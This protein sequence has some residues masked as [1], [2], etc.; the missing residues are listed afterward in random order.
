MA[1]DPLEQITN[2]E[3]FLELIK[4][5]ERQW[6]RLQTI[7][8]PGQELEIWLERRRNSAPIRHLA[9]TY[10]MSRYNIRQT[11]ARVEQKIENLRNLFSL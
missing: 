1:M 4:Q 8:F 5:S 11:I 9:I 6:D 3:A 10:H 2:K 7:F